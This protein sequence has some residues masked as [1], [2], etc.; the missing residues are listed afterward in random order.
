MGIVRP[1]LGTGFGCPSRQ[2]RYVLSLLYAFGPL[3]L[4]DRLKE[5][6]QRYDSLEDALAA[7]SYPNPVFKLQDLFS[8]INGIPRPAIH[9]PGKHN[10]INAFHGSALQYE[11]IIADLSLKSKQNSRVLRFS[12]LVPV[13]LCFQNTQSADFYTSSDRAWGYV[14]QMSTKMQRKAPEFSAF[15]PRSFL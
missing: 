9:R 8:G 7:S 13:I 14:Y 5:I 3:C 4:C 12:L 2:T 1:I 6:Y 15:S 10:L 11:Y